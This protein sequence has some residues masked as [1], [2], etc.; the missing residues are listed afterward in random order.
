MAGVTHSIE[1]VTVTIITDDGTPVTD[2]HIRVV[3]I[4]I[5]VGRHPEDANVAL[6]HC[7]PPARV[8]RGEPAQA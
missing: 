3:G 5:E 6:R 8:F 2:E 7:V 4:Y 1:D